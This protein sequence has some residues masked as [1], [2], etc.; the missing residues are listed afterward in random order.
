ARVSRGGEELK[1]D[2]CCDSAFRFFP[3]QP[4]SEFG[5]CLHPADLATNKM[6][7]LAGRSEVRDFIDILYLHQS[8]LSIGALCWAACGKD[9]GF[10]PSS[11][12]DYAKRHAKLQ[13]EELAGGYLT[14]P[15]QPAEMKAVWFQAVEQA[16][17]WF[18]QLPVAD[19]G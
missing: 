12:L 10:T 6:L 14:Q 18:A 1:L 9:L 8:Y 5:W 15:L 17:Q 11:I 19:V 4:D 2:W 16:E 3:V 13:P 7:A